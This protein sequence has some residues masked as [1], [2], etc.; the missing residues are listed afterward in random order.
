MFGE[1]QVVENVARSFADLV[2]EITPA[3]MALSGGSTARSCYELLATTDIDWSGTDFWFGDERWVPIHDPD[4]N[5]GM[6][7]ETFLDEIAPKTIHSMYQLD[8]HGSALAIEEA[9]RAYQTELESAGPIE[10][11]HLGLGPDGH[12]A[13]LFPDS[14]A[15]NETDRLVVP[16]GDGLHPHPRLTLT[17]PALATAPLI[18][19]TVA[20]AKKHDAL[21]RIRNDE[22]L[23]A[24]RVKAARIIWLIDNAAANGSDAKQKA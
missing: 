16:N 14:E 11:I 10:L 17:Y 5:E 18:V 4:S 21:E 15:L 6:A 7:R 19:F 13:S 23:P 1:L 2:A 20:G 24:G 22:N 8:R 12:T 3:S 9:A